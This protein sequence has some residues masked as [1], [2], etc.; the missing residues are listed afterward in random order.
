MEEKFCHGYTDENEKRTHFDVTDIECKHS[1][2]VNFRLVE[3]ICVIL[4]TLFFLRNKLSV[5]PWQKKR[6]KE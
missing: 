4:T 2:I 1:I 5:H 3:N 6:A